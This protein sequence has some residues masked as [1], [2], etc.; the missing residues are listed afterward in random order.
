[1]ELFCQDF[2]FLRIIVDGEDTEKILMEI[3]NEKQQRKKKTR[4]VIKRKSFRREKEPQNVD[5]VTSMV[6]G[7]QVNH[8]VPDVGG[9][10]ESRSQPQSRRNSN[11]P[12]AL[13]INPTEIVRRASNVALLPPGTSSQRRDSSLQVKT[14]LALKA[15]ALSWILL[16]TTLSISMQFKFTKICFVGK[17]KS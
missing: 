9:L 11:I 13:L 7:L 8:N 5:E 4:K 17:C 14:N 16:L 3:E 15:T 1:M 6:G 2:K 12:G 10:E